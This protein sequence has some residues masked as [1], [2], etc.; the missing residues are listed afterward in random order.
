[1]AA[2]LPARPAVHAAALA[3]KL[4]TPAG[5]KFVDSVLSRMGMMFSSSEI[6]PAGVAIC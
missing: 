2:Q 5:G 6:T 1:M 3:D 4:Y